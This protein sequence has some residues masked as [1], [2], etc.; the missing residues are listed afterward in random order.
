[1]CMINRLAHRDTT[2][3]MRFRCQMDS[4]FKPYQVYDGAFGTPSYTA[5]IKVSQGDTISV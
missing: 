4:Y 5:I 3:N 1:M 2:K